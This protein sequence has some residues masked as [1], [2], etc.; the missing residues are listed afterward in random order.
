MDQQFAMKSEVRGA[1]VILT[2]SGYINN[3]GGEA[4]AAECLSQ[5]ARG[6]KHVVL[7]LEQSRVVNSI[8]MS[9]IIEVIEQ[10]QESGSRSWG[11]LNSLRKWP[12][13][14]MRCP[15]WLPMLPRRGKGDDAPGGNTGSVVCTD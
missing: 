1:C 15:F 6:V 10:L 13:W 8:G 14:M 3:V 11:F 4:I 5:F 7:N 12:L 9:Y 2:T